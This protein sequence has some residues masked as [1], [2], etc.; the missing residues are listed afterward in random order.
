[1]IQVYLFCLCSLCSILRVSCHHEVRH[2][3]TSCAQPPGFECTYGAIPRETTLYHGRFSFGPGENPAQGIDWLAFEPEYAI[4]FLLLSVALLR[5]ETSRAKKCLDI[6]ISTLPICQ[7]Q[8]V[9]RV[10]ARSI[11]SRHEET[12]ESFT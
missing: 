1:M 7:E 6:T 8:W 10:E 9:G 12:F 4:M 11:L 5:A 3:T 2:M